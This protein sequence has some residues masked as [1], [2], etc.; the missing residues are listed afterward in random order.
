LQT[1]GN[2]DIIF[3]VKG[4]YVI[5]PICQQYGMSKRIHHLTPGE[6][7]QSTALFCRYCKTEYIV[8]IVDGQCVQRQ[9]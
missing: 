2:R 8:D 7:C 3:P 6:Q 4:G 5:C 1:P 9:S